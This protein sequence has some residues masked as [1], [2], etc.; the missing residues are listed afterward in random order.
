MK[1]LLTLV[2]FIQTTF[3][4]YNKAK[5]IYV[6]D[7]SKEKNLKIFKELFQSR[8]YLASATFLREY[9]ENGS[10]IPDELTEWID[11][12]VIKT[13]HEVFDSVDINRLVAQPS[14]SLKFVASE[15]LFKQN[16]FNEVVSLLAPFPE[17]HKFAPEAILT[18]GIALSEMGRITEANKSLEQCQK[19]ADELSKKNDSEK[20][21]RYY[22]IISEK[23]LINRARNYFYEKSYHKAISLYH[24]IPKTSYTWPYTLMEMAWSHFYLEDYNRVLGLLVTYKSPLLSSY[25]FPEAEYLSS[26]SYLKL[27]Q[28][29][30]ASVVIDK[31]DSYY[32]EK[33]NDLKKILAVNKNS[34]TYFLKLT[35]GELKEKEEMNPYIRNLVTQVRKRIRY[36]LDLINLKRSILEEKAIKN[37]KQDAFSNELKERIGAVINWK[38]RKINHFIKKEMFDFINQVHRF[39]YELF[40]VSL[41]VISNKKD[42]LYKGQALTNERTRGS[43]NNIKRTEL[44]NFWT[45]QGAFWA[46]ELGDYSFGLESKCKVTKVQTVKGR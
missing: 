24:E 25:F 44:Q 11:T 5:M 16:R 12:L 15:R 32:R 31:Y 30:D 28:Y 9:I 34:D 22:T 10:N 17:K 42:L 8:Y 41:E 38:R 37:L 3:A 21:E 33:T 43:E 27:C 7:Q 29:D 18:R 45:F 2:L 36:S 13:G 23:C 19:L 35:L 40:N 14:W 20:L 6:Q 26:L 1:I 4:S 39:S 46:D